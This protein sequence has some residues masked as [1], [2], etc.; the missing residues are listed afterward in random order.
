MNREINK[1]AKCKECCKIIVN[2]QWH[3]ELKYG[4]SVE[5][6]RQNDGYQIKNPAEMVKEGQASKKEI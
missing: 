5:S 6:Q 2:K 3:H 4:Y 1:E